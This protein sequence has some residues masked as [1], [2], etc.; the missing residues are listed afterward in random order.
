MIKRHMLLAWAKKQGW[1]Y[2]RDVPFK[3]MGMSKPTC[4]TALTD[5]CK[6]GIMDYRIVG[7]KQYR[8]K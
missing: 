5:F 1:F 4:G 8:I 3:E 7:L 6:R 2:L